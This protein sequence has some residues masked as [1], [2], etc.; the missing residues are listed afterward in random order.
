MKNSIEQKRKFLIGSSDSAVQGKFAKIVEAHIPRSVVF[1]ANDG[2]NVLQK[3]ENDIPHVLIVDLHLGKK[4]AE[5]VV[6][7]VLKKDQEIPS[8]V[9]LGELPEV[10]QFADE[11]AVGRVQFIS[12]TSSDSQVHAALAR[13][14]NWFSKGDGLEYSVKF[15]TGGQTLI[16]K[17][18]K[19]DFVYILKS[20]QMEAVVYEGTLEIVLGK[21]SPQEFVG[22][23]AY[24]NGE[25]RSA[26]VIA[27]TDC[28]L[29]EI[30]IGHL[31]KLLFQKPA[32]AKALM[33]T[34]TKRIELFNKQRLLEEKE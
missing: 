33:K 14:L 17:G 12:P 34:L 21:I 28:E 30:P 10:D 32:W 2:F 5:E 25:P 23:M 13:A 3:L 4:S 27:R 9:I 11:V 15:L 29:I 8:I 24:V 20:G 19:A 16:R 26:D 18:E 31:D 6:E 1:S 7:A 22:E